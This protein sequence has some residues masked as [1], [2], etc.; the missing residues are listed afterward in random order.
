MQALNVGRKVP[1][2]L[3]LRDP[4]DADRRILPELMKRSRQQMLVE[5]MR[6]RSQS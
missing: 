4:I 6:Q 5:H 2:V 1:P 3:L